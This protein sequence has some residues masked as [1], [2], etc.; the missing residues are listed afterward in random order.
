L[1]YVSGAHLEKE[2]EGEKVGRR[3]EDSLFLTYLGYNTAHKI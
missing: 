3:R 1:I 2:E